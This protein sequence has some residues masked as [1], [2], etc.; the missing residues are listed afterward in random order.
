MMIV[1]KALLKR[2]YILKKSVIGGYVKS[3]LYGDKPET[4]DAG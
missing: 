2:R 1:H 4:I 3:L